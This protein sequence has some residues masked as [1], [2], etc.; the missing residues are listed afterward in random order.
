MHKGKTN[1]SQML[2]VLN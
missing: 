1:K 2:E